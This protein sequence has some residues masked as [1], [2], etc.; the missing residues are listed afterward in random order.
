MSKPKVTSFI[1][2]LLNF[3]Q[4][5]N[6]IGYV[7]VE[8]GQ[9]VL[10]VNSDICPVSQEDVSTGK[11]AFAPSYIITKADK[12]GNVQEIVVDS[13]SLITQ[14]HEDNNNQ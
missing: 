6:P 9:I 8:T 12:K 7:D 14:K 1:P 13:F 11:A 3:D 4:S 2:I 10:K 5:S